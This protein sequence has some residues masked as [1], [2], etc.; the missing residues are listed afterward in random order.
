MANNILLKKKNLLTKILKQPDYDKYDWE[1]YINDYTDLVKNG[2]NTKE[3][4]IRHWIKYGQKEGRKM[5][6]LSDNININI[7]IDIDIDIY[8]LY[9]KELK[10]YTDNELI[11]HFNMC[12]MSEDRIHDIKSFNLKFNLNLSKKKDIID[13]YNNIKNKKTIYIYSPKIDDSCGGVGALHN[14]YRLILNNKTF[15]AQII[16]FD[17]FKRKL[18]KLTICQNRTE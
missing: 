17:H 5:N 10:K 14:L 6:L 4:A 11:N 12:G 16:T 18:K 13:Y 3:Q 9:N 7:D 1:K 8:R 2:I 15:N